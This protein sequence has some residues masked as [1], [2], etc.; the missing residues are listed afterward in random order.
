MLVNALAPEFAKGPVL[1]IAPMEPMTP[2][3]RDR[4][5]GVYVGIDIDPAADQRK[6]QVT[7]DLRSLPFSS[8]SF[9]AIIC[10]HVLEHI[11]EDRSAI[12]ELARVLAVDGLALLQVPWR[13]GSTTDEDPGASRE[14]R[15]RRFG[16]AD[17]VRYYGD[18]FED[19]L[20]EAGLVT[21]RLTPK[22]VLEATAIRLVGLIADEPVWIVAHDGPAMDRVSR[23][24]LE[25]VA[26]RLPTAL[27][28]AWRAAEGASTAA[29]LRQERPDV[30][31]GSEI[32]LLVTALQEAEERASEWEKSYRWL[33]SR[34]P[35]RIVAGIARFGR[36]LVRRRPNTAG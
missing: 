8:G 4:A 13:Q 16:Q 26:R 28:A 36:R 35:V 1:D 9:Q 24:D 29:L 17:H 3:L 30:P 34:W 20:Q 14:E 15:V 23:S 10:Y 5:G 7:A 21:L 32:Q 33:R 11:D 27:I 31:P 2:L 18:D 25:W 12:V 19:R 6:V 22:D